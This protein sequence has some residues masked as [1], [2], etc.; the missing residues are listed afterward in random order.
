MKQKTIKQ[1]EEQYCHIPKSLLP[2]LGIII[3]GLLAYGNFQLID[4]EVISEVFKP[5]GETCVYNLSTS[6]LINICPIIG[7]YILISLFLISLIAFSKGGY[8]KLN[9]WDDF[10][11]ISGLIF[12][13][14]FSLISGLIFGLISGLIFG[15]IF[16]LILGLQAEFKENFIKTK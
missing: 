12:G 13:L 3:F 10:G 1:H 4:K 2:L 9:K 6:D 7:E 16:G 15:L 5:C 11:L 8:N 14:I